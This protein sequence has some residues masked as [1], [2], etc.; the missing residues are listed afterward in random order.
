MDFDISPFDKFDFDKKRLLSLPDGENYFQ[1]D[2]NSR[3][4]S[5]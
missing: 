5:E 3:L 1:D 2:K 4:L